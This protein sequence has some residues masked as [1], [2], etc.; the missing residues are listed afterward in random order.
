[1]GEGRIRQAAPPI[2]IYRKPADAFVA[3]FIGSTNLLEV[4]ANSAGRAAI[5]GT[6]VV[7]LKLPAGVSKASISIRPE[8]VHIAAPG[9]GGSD[10]WWHLMPQDNDPATRQ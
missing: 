7:G 1:M 9:N 3:D 5:F 6:P 10:I 2:E 4:A 8:D